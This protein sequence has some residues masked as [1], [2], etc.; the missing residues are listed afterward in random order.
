MSL[1][2]K[3]SIDRAID[4]MNTSADYEDYI[5]I[6][7]KPAE[8]GCCC[9]HCWPE[10]WIT[11]NKYIYPCGPIKDE[12]DVLIDKNNV[13][14]VLECHESGPEIIVYLGLGTASI[15]LAKSVIDLITT[16]L[17]TR[18]NEVRNRSGKFKIIRRSQIKGQVEEEE[19]MELD[20]PLS[21]DIIK[22]LNDNIQNAIEKK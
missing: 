16:L 9:F 15:V 21:E 4:L 19:I 11:V 5:S 20:L 12:G 10:T 8:G 3:R 6:K 13:K 1:N 17:K 2:L 22:K 14:F 7:I 18:Q